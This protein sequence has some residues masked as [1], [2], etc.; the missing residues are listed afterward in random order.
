VPV[1]QTEAGI[2]RQLPLGIRLRDSAV[3]D[4]FFP[5]PNAAALDYLK[6]LAG[7]WASAG[8]WVW[9]PSGCGKTHLLQAVCAAVDG[10]E[11]QAAYLPMATMMDLGAG[12]LE[13][14]GSK[15]L[16]AIDDFD[17]AAG[18]GGLEQAVFR[19]YNELQEQGGRLL[20]S[21]TLAPAGLDI[22]LPDL[23]SRLAAGVIFQLAPLDDAQRV[24]ALQL[25]AR[26]RGLELPDE[27]AQ[28]LLRRL[29]RD[30][31]SLC[32]WLD[33]LDVASLEAQRRLTVPFVREVMR[34]PDQ[35]S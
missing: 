7:G 8:A 14:W 2:V 5:G 25:R 26:H 10:P 19:L 3:F 9:G 6:S 35:D 16:I 27:T 34:R 22:R 17:Q 23:A 1:T 30:M 20:V 12:A 21:T 32:G 33:R 11:R 28:F 18:H 4:T 24:S 13:G 29:P 15:Q 31:A